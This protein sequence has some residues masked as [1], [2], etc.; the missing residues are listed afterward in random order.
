MAA[1]RPSGVVARRGTAGSRRSRTSSRPRP[2]AEATSQRRRVSPGTRRTTR[3]RR[4]AGDAQRKESGRR[5]RLFGRGGVRRCTTRR[6]VYLP[7]PAASNGRQCT[8]VAN[9]MP[10]TRTSAL[11]EAPGGGCKASRRPRTWESRSRVF[12][13]LWTHR[14][15][16]RSRHLQVSGWRRP[17]EPVQRPRTSRRAASSAI[18]DCPRQDSNP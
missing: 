17:R 6:F 1:V 12:N 8:C 10:A 7:T 3:R 13:P 18:T 4:A 11:A 5:A 15:L 16:G 2:P 9:L 14:T